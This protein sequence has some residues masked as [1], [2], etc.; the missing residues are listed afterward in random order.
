VE[1]KINF[2]EYH[3]IRNMNVLRIVLGIM[4]DLID[5]EIM[6]DDEISKMRRSIYVKLNEY[7]RY[8]GLKNGKI[9]KQ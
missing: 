3:K 5:D 9:F 4:D 7:Y 6:S 8:H 2:G 1:K